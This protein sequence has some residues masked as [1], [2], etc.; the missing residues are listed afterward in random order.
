MRE[1]RS[2]ATKYGQKPTNSTPGISLTERYTISA[3]I[4]IPERPS[5]MQPI[6]SVSIF[7]IGLS[8]KFTSQSTTDAAARL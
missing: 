1:V 2:A 7:S 6:G 4:K 5:V 3:L 8:V